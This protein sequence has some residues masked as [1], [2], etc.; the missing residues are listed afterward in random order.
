MTLPPKPKRPHRE[1][2]VALSYHPERGDQAARVVASGKGALAKQIVD[3]AFAANIKVREDADLVE[4][5]S[6]VD[7]DSLI[8]LE[9]FMAVAEI[10]TYLYRVN[11]AA[12]PARDAAP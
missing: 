9:A 8:P 5:L 11:G 1:S 12:L 4:L 7:V 10:L 2:A 6:S 3:T